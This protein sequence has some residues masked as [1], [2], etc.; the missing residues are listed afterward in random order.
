MLQSGI[1]VDRCEILDSNSIEAFNRYS[2]EVDA[3]PL[4]PH[5]FL[6]FSGPTEASVDAFTDLARSICSEDF[7]CSD[8]RFTSDDAKRASLWSARHQL[9]YASLALRPGASGIVTDVCV[10]LSQLANV[11]QATADDVKELDVVGPCFG[12]AGDGNFHCIL[13][14]LDSDTEDYLS[15]VEEVN[16]RL[17][18]RAILVGG[19]VTGEH[20]VGYGKIKYLSKLYG[21]NTVKMMGM[22]KRSLDPNNIMNPGKV[23]A[24]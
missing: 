1:P 15:R 17:I 12:H 16:T 24:L 10:P 13:P 23:I 22:I 6:D 2:S 7:S 9:Y 5:L 20:G 4:K 11:I 3:L 8:F 21:D 19:T 18:N 14:I